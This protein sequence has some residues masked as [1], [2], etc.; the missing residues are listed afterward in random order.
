MIT[1]LVVRLLPGLLVV[2]L[3]A[4]T[5][6][7][8]GR[9]VPV[10]GKVTVKGVPLKNGS[11]AYWPDDGKDKAGLTPTSQIREDGTYDLIT[12]SKPGAPPGKYKVTVTAQTEVDSTKAETAKSLVPAVYNTKEKT[13]LVK[14]VVASPAA[15]AYDLELK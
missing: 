13:P 9:T 10:K 2:T 1:R 3:S 11:V 6:D 15:G 7:P 14:E 12:R 4:C 8:V 5:D